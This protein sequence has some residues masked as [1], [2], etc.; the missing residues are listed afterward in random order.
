MLLFVVASALAVSIVASV[1]LSFLTGYFF[2]TRGRRSRAFLIS[3]SVGVAAIC[4]GMLV[5]VLLVPLVLQP[6]V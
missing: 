2:M 6:S 4:G 3:G 5:K 1:C